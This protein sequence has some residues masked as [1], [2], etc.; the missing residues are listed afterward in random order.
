MS[1]P[2]VED[3]RAPGRYRFSLEGP[4]VLITLVADECVPRQMIL[5]DS[6]W[7]PE[8]EKPAISTRKIV[9]TGGDPPPKL[10]PAPSSAGS[11]PSF[12]G[13][14][15]VG[16]RRRPAP[17]RP[18]ERQ[19]RRE[20]LLA[21]ADSRSRALES[22]SSGAIACS[23]R[24]RSA[25]ARR[26]VQARPLWRRRC[27]G[28]SLD[29]E[30]GALRASTNARERSSGSAS[31]S[32][33]SRGNKRHIKSTYAS[34]SPATDGR[35]VVAWFGSQGIYA[36]DMTASCCWKVDLGRVD[37]GAYDIPVVRVGTGQLADH[38]ERP[39]DRA[40]R[41]AGG[42]VRARARRRTP[43]R[44]C[45]RPIAQE[46]PS[47]GTPTVVTIGDRAELVTNAANFIRGYDPRTGEE[48]WRLGGSSKI[49][50]PTPIF[51][52]GLIIVASGRRPERPIF[53][54]RPGARG[55]LTLERRHTSERRSSVEQERAR[56]LHA[57]AARLRR[58]LVLAE[59][60]RRVRRL[61]S[62]RPARKSIVSGWSRSAAD[63]AL[64]R[65]PR[66]AGSIFRTK[67][68]T[69]W[70]LPPGG[71]FRLIRNESNG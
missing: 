68:A 22:R 8:G 43:A 16:C 24:A 33:G 49:T 6:L 37:M 11:W 61:R 56:P 5:H 52:N 63:S 31:P 48:L 9:R 19:D 60:R 7:L 26:D 39:G 36:Y 28:R 29:A 20:H 14:Q 62:R 46:L 34:A 41:H 13:P 4:R 64:R 30:M 66:T 69:C 2:M 23:S 38:L 54:V 32:K 15:R 44:P 67:T 10:S 3:C 70:S 57:D 1:T 50:A 53:A 17:A 65:S 18:M 59:Q 58:H 71:K 25:A 12:R 21:H 55:D 45:G 51:A 27:V 35:I 42:L 40:V 47:W